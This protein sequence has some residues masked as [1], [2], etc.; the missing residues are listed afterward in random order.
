MTENKRKGNE[1][2]DLNSASIV[3]FL[4]FSDGRNDLIDIC[5]K[6]GI[7]LLNFHKTIKLLV[8]KKLVVE[9]K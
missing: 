4:A 8:E 2:L 6:T 1:P 7:D 9:K 5:E 3:N